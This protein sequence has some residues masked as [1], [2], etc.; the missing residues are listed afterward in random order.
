MAQSISQE[1]IG[2]TGLP[3][4]TSASRHA[5]ATTSGAPVSGTFAVGDF[6]VD[7]SGAMYVCT[8]AGT[9]GTWQLS[10]V[11]VN[12]NIAGKN[13][14][15]NGGMDI[16]QRGT[17]FAP[18]ASTVSTY[19][20][21]RWIHFR[22]GLVLGSTI[23]QVAS[24]LT[25]FNY[26]MRVQRNSGNTSTQS[27]QISTSIETQNSLPMAGQTVNFS[28]WARAGANYSGS[29]LGA[30]LQYGTGTD[31]LISNGFT[32]ATTI[33][34]SNSALTT[35]W[36]RFTYS[37]TVAST[38]TQLGCYFSFTPTGTAGANDYYDITGVQLEIAPQATP[39]SRAG[40]S[41]G[42]EL[43]LCQRYFWQITADTSNANAVLA[44]IGTAN[45]TTSYATPV[46]FPVTMRAVPSTTVAFANLQAVDGANSYTITSLSLVGGTNS[47]QTGLLY[48]GI[49]VGTLTQ[50]RPYWT[51]SSVAGGYIGIT[52][53]L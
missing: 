46:Q 1:A 40:G 29:T 13:F 44:G 19:T 8:V 30:V 43:A 51:R 35:S 11:S 33:S 14:V 38:A 17:S 39:F 3:G 47:T 37:A 48:F 12:E 27:L 20:A 28:F 45:T 21:D 53:E 22:G 9:P 42:G 31:Q 24:G 16:W 36:Q 4:A 49:T 5:G 10:G 23:A 2:A 32:G 7:Q 52:A 25:G 34:T 41:I 6:I 15:I 18:S 50:F 26:A